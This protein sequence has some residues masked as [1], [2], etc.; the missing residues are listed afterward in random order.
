VG[1]EGGWTYH[2]AL[3][4]QEDEVAGD[5]VSGY[6]L[7]PTLISQAHLMGIVMEDWEVK[8]GWRNGRLV[9]SKPWRIRALEKFFEWSRGE[10]PRYQALA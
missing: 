1:D 10:M 5:N 3:P 6:R 4:G 7:N 9:L 2:F 8:R